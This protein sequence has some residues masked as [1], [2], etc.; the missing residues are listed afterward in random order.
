MTLKQQL[1]SEKRWKMRWEFCWSCKAQRANRVGEIQHYRNDRYYCYY[2][3]WRL[4]WKILY[5]KVSHCECDFVTS[6][7]NQR[8][9]YPSWVSL[10]V[11]PLSCNYSFEQLQSVFR[12]VCVLL[13]ISI[14][15]AMKKHNMSNHAF[16]CCF[17]IWGVFKLPAL[18]ANE[19]SA[20]VPWPFL[21][22]RPC[23]LLVKADEKRSDGQ[24]NNF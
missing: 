16:V 10:Q 2:Y 18:A 21:V 19:W 13:S 15:W 9:V 1:N 14:E 12:A 22:V 24:Q 7:V 6:Q 8:S 5:A 3:C 11:Q 17:S 23:W 4:D 20:W